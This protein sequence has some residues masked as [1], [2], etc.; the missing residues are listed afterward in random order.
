M[1]NRTISFGS[2]FAFCLGGAVFIVIYYLPIWFQAIHGVS[3]MQ[4]GIDNIPLILS[5]VL[6]SLTAGFVTTMIGYYMPFIYISSIMMPIGA[7]MLTTFAVNTPTREWIGYQ[8][9]LGIG[10]GC[11]FQQSIIAAQA[12]LPMADI[13]SGTTAV[14][15][16]QL[17]GGALMVTAG[18]NVFTTRLTSGLATIPGVDAQMV[19]AT[20]ATKLKELITN[21]ADYNDALEIYNSGLTRAYRVSLVVACLAVIGAV[22]ME[23]KS[24]KIKPA[25]DG[26]EA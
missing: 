9:I 12:V 26:S 11:G 4:S 10:V 6:A 19:I 24:V 3:P 22:G 15:F 13:P 25:S 2:L 5:Q 1:A 14:L 18:Q 17:L 21:P 16:F 20:G 23:F 8:I 7:G